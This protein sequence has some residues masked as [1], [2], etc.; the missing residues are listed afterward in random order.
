MMGRLARHLHS[1]RPGG[2]FQVPG[3]V[4]LQHLYDTADAARWGFHYL[5]GQSITSKGAFLADVGQVFRFPGYAGQNWDAFEELMRDLDWLSPQPRLFVYDSPCTLARSQ[6][7]AWFTARSILASA[8]QS[9]QETS[10]P[11][12]ILL[13][14]A[15]R[16]GR[17]IAWLS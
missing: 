7:G 17:G 12:L 11:L 16:A 2:L 8:A 3:G 4:G 13:R 10:T 9:W 14:H 1:P 5:D 6:P 15:G